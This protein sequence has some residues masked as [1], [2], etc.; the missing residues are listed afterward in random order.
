MC[1]SEKMHILANNCIFECLIQ[2]CKT[3][4]RLS[5]ERIF[6]CPIRESGCPNN[7]P[8]NSTRQS[9]TTPTNSNS[10]SIHHHCTRHA[11]FP[12]LGISVRGHAFHCTRCQL[13]KGHGGSVGHVVVVYYLDTI[14]QAI[15]WNSSIFDSTM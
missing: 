10:A 12:C 4:L 6:Q 13:A 15:S 11:I 7:N 14:T 9:S 3:M 8:S 2:G 1:I 5:K